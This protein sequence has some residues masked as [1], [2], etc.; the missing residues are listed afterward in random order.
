MKNKQGYES[1]ALKEIGLYIHI[2]FCKSKCFYCDFNSFSGKEDLI[3]LY[4]DA[5]KAEIGYYSGSLK[6]YCIKT[7]FIGGGTPSYVEAKYIC[8]LMEACRGAFNIKED[9]EISI[10][11][12]PG[13]LD[14][15]K[16]SFYKSKGINRL[17][18]G[19]QASQ[20][21][22]LGEMGRI[23]SR[24]DYSHNF[25]LAR[26]A[27]FEN[28][29]IDIIFGLPGQTLNEWNQTVSDVVKSG[30]EHV[31]CYSLR[32]EEETIFGQRFK[33]GTLL[34]A[35]DELDRS[36]YY[37]AIEKLMEHERIHYEISNFAKPGYECRHNLIYWKAEEYL[38]IGAGAH[39]YLQGIRF[40]NVYGIERYVSAISK[41]QIPKENQQLID[42]NE[43][44]AEFMILGLRL[45]AGINTEEFKE[46][47]G[48]NIFSVFG[49]KLE[50][51]NKKQLIELDGRKIRLTPVGLDLANQAFMEFI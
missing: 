12:N 43:K 44:M 27:G 20:D 8:Q 14:A 6:D 22:L 28:I 19:L 17:S 47:F 7:V 30:S 23:H 51:L 10:E 40:N 38:G 46:R 11:A 48:L 33:N 31:S 36:M 37:F 3:S 42:I 24:A 9:A 13:T 32:I 39:S 25:N 21:R 4:F 15:E 34:P 45:V 5:L 49:R 50:K 41:G 1:T 2:P 35:D 29:N 16:L 18:L 26:K